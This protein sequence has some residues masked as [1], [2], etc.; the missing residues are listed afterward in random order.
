[1]SEKTYMI[2]GPLGPFYIPAWPED[3]MRSCEKIS[4]D[5]WGGEY[6]HPDLPA[7][8]IARILDVGACLGAFSVWARS[9]W[10]KDVGVVSYEPYDAAYEYLKLNAGA[11]ETRLAAVTSA[12]TASLNVCSDW[13][14]SSTTFHWWDGRKIQVPVVHPRDLPSCDLLKID[15]EGVEA[16]VLAE[17]PHWDGLRVIMYEW[18]SQPLRLECMRTVCRRGGFRLLAERESGNGVC[19]WGRA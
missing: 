14:M 4:R 16:E 15:A 10:G 7:D 19:I 18:H 6:A 1:M 12:T 8:G 11:T 5:V 9:V 13:G 17:Y 3:T 2:D